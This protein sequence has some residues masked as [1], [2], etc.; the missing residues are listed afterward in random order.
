MLEL[1]GAV[2]LIDGNHFEGAAVDTPEPVAY[3]RESHAGDHC[4]GIRL[5][6]CQGVLYRVYIAQ[7]RPLGYTGR[8]AVRRG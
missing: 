2:T 5:L 3:I 8:Q 1:D 7:L 4:S 6:G